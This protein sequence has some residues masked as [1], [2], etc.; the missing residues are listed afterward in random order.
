MPVSNFLRMFLNT[1]PCTFPRNLCFVRLALAMALT[2]AVQNAQPAVCAAS[3]KLAGYELEQVTSAN[4]KY[5][6]TACAKAVRLDQLTYGYSVISCAPNW[7]VLIF[8]PDT[9]KYAQVPYKEW[10]K[11]NLV[12]VTTLWTMELTKPISSRHFEQ[13]GQGY[14]TYVFACTSTSSAFLSPTGREESKALEQN[15]G[16]IICL[17]FPADMHAG[18][19]IGRAIALP[20]LQ[21]IALQATRKSATAGGWT[22]KTVKTKHDENISADLF[23][24][25]QGLK[26]VPFGRSLLL[27]DSAKGGVDYMFGD[28]PVK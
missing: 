10:L 11:T 13:G 6:V 7:D 16:E 20:E 1:V 2:A 19:V 17:D 15:R 9:K 23:V 18:G 28:A 5:K 22:L 27:S 26:K 24:L 14:I 8:R 3:K 21:G 4:G 12:V 25:P